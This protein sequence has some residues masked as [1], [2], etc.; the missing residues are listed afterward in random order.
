MAIQPKKGRV[1]KRSSTRQLKILES[2]TGTDAVAILRVLAE[3]NE[4]VAHEI[5]AIA[6]ELFS[7]VAIDDVAASV[8][9]ELESIDIED[10]FDR[11]GSKRGGYVD[12]GDAVWEMFEEALEPFR[13]EVTKYRQLSMQKEAELTCL[14]ILKGIYAFHK[15]SSTEYKKWAVD[16]PGEYFAM[17]LVD[18]KS[19]FRGRLP[20]QR[21]REFLETHCPEWAEWGRKSLGLKGRKK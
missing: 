15:E 11:A 14:G 10:V 6:R 16:A 18:W 2:I 19:L 5:D 12:P 3:R 1:R 7:H 21:M 4:S 8:Q 17:I 20:L 9:V 13:D